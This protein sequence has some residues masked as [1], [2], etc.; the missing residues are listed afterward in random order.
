MFVTQFSSSFNY[1][2]LWRKT[3]ICHLSLLQKSLRFRPLSP[4]APPKRDKERMSS[5]LSALLCTCTDGKKTQTGAYQLLKMTYVEE[6]K[7]RRRISCWE[8]EPSRLLFVFCRAQIC[9][10]SGEQFFQKSRNYRLTRSKISIRSPM[11]TSPFM[12]TVCGLE[13]DICQSLEPLSQK[14][15]PSTSQVQKRLSTVWKSFW[16]KNSGKRL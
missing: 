7:T 13:S 16:R 6:P 8:F 9:K 15:H 4:P 5:R 2:S 14:T 1:Y 11:S 10:K 12:G 3:N